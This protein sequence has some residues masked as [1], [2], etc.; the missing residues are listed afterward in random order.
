MKK[1]A[2]YLAGALLMGGAGIYAYAY[3]FLSG[4]AYKGPKS[5]HFDGKEFHNLEP[6]EMKSFPEV[7]SW[8]V[9]RD[10]GPWP[11]EI[12]PVSATVPKSAVQT[13][14]EVTFVN[15]ASLLIQGGGVNVITDP[16][17]SERASP[18][19]FAGPERLREPGVK[20]QDLPAIHAVLISHNHYDHLD[21]ETLTKLKDDFDPLFIVPLGVDLL[22]QENGITN[23][24]A[25]DWF[26]TIDLPQGG[27]VHC[28]PAR[29][30]SGRGLGDTNQTLWAGYVVEVAGKKIYFAGDTGYGAFYKLIK[31]RIG[32]PDLALLPIGAYK[33]E[34]FMQP[35]HMSP[36][37]AVMAH[38]DLEATQSIGMHFG[39]FPM[40]DDGQAEPVEDLGLARKKLGIEENEFFALQEGQTH[41]LKE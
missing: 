10:K 31:E 24:A 9:N 8:Q 28:A 41:T 5:N 13:G 27:V 14:V 36:E 39:T 4:P 19:S 15:H 33:P 6:T 12:Q 20:Y 26:D 25:M 29:H 35:I 21:L 32:A 30:F 40:A 23:V 1:A 2:V 16:I 3:K 38:L 37:E 7:L 11:N 18:V 22:L 34:W 17:W